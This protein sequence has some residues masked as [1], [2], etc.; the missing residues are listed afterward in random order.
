MSASRVLILGGAG[1]LGHRLWLHCA[2]RFDTRVTLRSPDRQPR[3][4][5]DPARVVAPVDADD[6]DAVAAA[7]NAFR[8]TDVVNCI[9]IV[10]QLAAAK[11]PVA[12][13]TVNA[14]FPHRVHR[15]CES[16]GARL[17]HVS[18][19]CVFAGTRGLYVESDTPDASDLYGR[20]KLLGEV[21]DGRA[22]TLRTSIIGRELK[23]ASGLTE[24][25]LS[26]R[27]G[28]VKGFETAIFSGVTTSV[29]SRLIGDVIEH[30][31][32]LTGLYHVA[33][34]PVNKLDLL[35]RLNDAFGTKTSIVPADD[36]R[37]DR[38]LDGTRF[39][40][41][42]GWSAPDWS[43]MVDGLARESRPYDEWR[44]PVVS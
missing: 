41:V 15:M 6:H 7:I 44:V 31:Q 36:V 32:A 27:G 35:R 26:Q 20:S 23:S 28:T 12:S 37:V 34:A 29:L 14:V 22:L 24:W 19:D 5:F 38:S 21:V 9:G 4:V 18:T 2:D 11:D 17:I 25:F 43:A 16:V 39:R 1:M 3:G 33:A 42:T 13:L 10:K 30:H 40:E 8:P